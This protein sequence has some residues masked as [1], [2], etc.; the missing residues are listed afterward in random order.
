MKLLLHFIDTNEPKIPFAGM[1]SI[2]SMLDLGSPIGG[3]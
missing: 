3:T 2:V 1:R